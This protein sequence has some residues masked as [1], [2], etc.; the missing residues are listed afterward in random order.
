MFNVWILNG[1]RQARHR[2]GRRGRDRGR[3]QGGQRLPQQPTIANQQG[4][5]HHHSFHRQ[6]KKGIKRGKMLLRCSS[7]GGQM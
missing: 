3:D 5:G 7:L 2:P 6:Q 4:R 1:I